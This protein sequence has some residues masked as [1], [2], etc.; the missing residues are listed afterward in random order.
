[1]SVPAQRTESPP[2]DAW[3]DWATPG[4]AYT[5]GAEEELML[6]HPP[7][8][9]L[10]Q[11][12]E[13]VLPSLPPRLAANVQG[14]THGSA[15]EI[16][17]AAH[18]RVADVERDLRALRRELTEALE[19][20]GLRAA[21]AGTHPFAVWH[22]TVVSSDERVQAVYGS[23]R[24]LARREPTFALHVHVGVTDPEDAIALMNRMR[25]HVPLLLAVSANSP[26]WQGRDTGLAS[27][28]TPLF[29][30][31]PR[32]GIP[33]VFNDY[34]DYVGAVDLLVRCG[35]IPEPTFLW[36]DVRPQ[37]R[38]GTVEVRIMD[39]QA[40]VEQTAAIVALVQSI[41]RLEVES[42]YVTPKTIWAAE[43]LDENRFLAARD[44]MDA[45]LIDVDTETRMPAREMLD[46]VLKACAPHAES[47]GCAS[48]LGRVRELA[49]KTGA[50]R[51]LEVAEEGDRLP[52]L[53]EHL[54]DQF[55]G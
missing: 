11:T 21:C 13:T 18:A 36:W 19:P 29:Q 4:E 44:G 22:D 47:L 17:S 52:G 43:V 34:A 5:V 46:D 20:M 7:G 32:V 38:F 28:R 45:N 23:M 53:V 30:A 33:R 26:F 51:Q 3:F 49:A 16:A 39:A 15:L 31:F 10:A 42:G 50:E 48:E 40:G 27:A 54:A 9:A 41:A 2:V 6:V 55:V 8:W 12:V 35:S 37:P 14:E 24:E 1:M 25:A